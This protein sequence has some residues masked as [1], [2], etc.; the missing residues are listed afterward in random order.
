MAEESQGFP[1]DQPESWRVLK[2]GS[3]RAEP[4][5]THTGP[6]GLILVV[7]LTESGIN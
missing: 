5:C 2:Q 4:A 3:D 6:S 7:N 1:G